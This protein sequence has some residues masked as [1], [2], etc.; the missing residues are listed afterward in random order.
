VRV[1][2]MGPC[3]CTCMRASPSVMHAAHQRFRRA[4]AAASDSI[5]G[6]GERVHVEHGGRLRE[7]RDRSIREDLNL[8]RV[9]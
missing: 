1:G 5:H 7:R 8:L 3:T 4:V 6:C 9:A 2:D